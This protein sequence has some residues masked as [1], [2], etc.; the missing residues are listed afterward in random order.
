LLTARVIGCSR[1]PVPPARMMPRM[2]AHPKEE[3][4]PPS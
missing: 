4:D 3:G 1:E 2:V